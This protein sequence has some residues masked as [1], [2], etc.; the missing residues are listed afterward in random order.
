MNYH[1]DDDDD[2][3]VDVRIFYRVMANDDNYGHWNDD[4]RLYEHPYKFQAL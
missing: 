4:M 1:D 2:D 3:V